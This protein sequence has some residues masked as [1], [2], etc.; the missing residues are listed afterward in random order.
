MKEYC[1]TY[2]DKDGISRLYAEC[3]NY[4]S[5]YLR[6]KRW[7]YKNNAFMISV[8]LVEHECEYECECECECEE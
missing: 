7:C 8:T 6:F 4:H 5:A 3:K 1:L 2:R